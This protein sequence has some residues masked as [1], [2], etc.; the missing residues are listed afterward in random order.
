MPINKIITVYPFAELSEK[1]KE[2]A[3]R[4]HQA[5]CGYDTACWAVEWIDC[6]VDA[7]GL[8]LTAWDAEY[9]TA[10]VKPEN[11]TT[12]TILTA[13]TTHDGGHILDEHKPDCVALLAKMD[14]MDRVDGLYYATMHRESQTIHKALGELFSTLEGETKDESTDLWKKMGRTVGHLI[15]KEVEY[16]ETEEYMA[17]H[18]DANE[19]LFFANGKIAPRGLPDAIPTPRI[20]TVAW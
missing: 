12:R 15:R 13:I 5:A 11:T 3:M 4:D 7:V 17:E 19:Y 9:G 1:A 14:K 18:F 6:E 8:K 20:E 16:T 2:K 10:T